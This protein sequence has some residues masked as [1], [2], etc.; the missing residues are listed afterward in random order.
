MANTPT[1]TMRMP[2]ELLDKCDQVAKELGMN[3][4]QYF[5]M[6][7]ERVTEQILKEI[8]KNGKSSK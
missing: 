4:T 7:L 1:T 8:K 6:V 5:I 2:L 3:R